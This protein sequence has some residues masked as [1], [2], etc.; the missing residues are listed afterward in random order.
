MCI[1]VISLRNLALL[2]YIEA[3]PRTARQCGREV[4][5]LPPCGLN[6][7]DLRKL[8]CSCMNSSHT[9]SRRAS[10]DKIA[11]S[12]RSNGILHT[13][14]RVH[15]TCGLPCRLSSWDSPPWSLD[16]FLP[17]HPLSYTTSTSG[18]PCSNWVIHT[19][20]SCGTGARLELGRP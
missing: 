1:I 18:L 2:G 14:V 13:E 20:A 10:Y 4:L 7:I 15:V 16:A 8:H 3:I 12:A 11:D 19:G 17:A 9:I 5:T 6:Q